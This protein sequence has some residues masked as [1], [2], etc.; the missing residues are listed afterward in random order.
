MRAPK[1][2]EATITRLS[3]Y[4]RYLMK[5]KR[6]GKI[7]TSSPDI[8]Q[9]AG[10]NPAQVRK[11]LS[12]FGEFGTRGVG[13][14]VEQLNWDVLKIL[15]LDE[16]WSVALV[17]F[18]H[19]GHAVAMHRVFK[20]RGFNFTS[21]FDRDPEKIGTK[22]KDIEILPMEQLEKVVAQNHTRIGIITTP[23]DSAQAIADSLVRAGVQAILNF[24]PVHLSVPETIELRE[25]DLAVN[26][27]VLT[28]HMEM[29]RQGF[30]SS[31]PANF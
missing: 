24:A 8:A 18:G 3:V 28:F 9:G 13:Y 10:V 17:G 29:Q 1:I 15:S 26:L 30:A 27:E 23:A 2:P 25:V 4:S 12:F 21:I 5:M 14:N 6:Q 31:R 16:E 20:E 19:L 22:V 7:T 11:D